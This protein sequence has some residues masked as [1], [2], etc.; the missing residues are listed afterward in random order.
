MTVHRRSWIAGTIV[1]ILVG[2][3]TATMAQNRPAPAAPDALLA[4]APRLVWERIV[5]LPATRTPADDEHR[6]W[7]LRAL[8]ARGDGGALIVAGGTSGEAARLIGVRGDGADAF[9][10]PLPAPA[11]VGKKPVLRSAALNGEGRDRI[12]VFL[13]WRPAGEP[14]VGPVA[15]Q[16]IGIDG[17]AYR[18]VVRQ[19]P[20]FVHRGLDPRGPL[21]VDEREATVLRR[22]PDGSLLAGGTAY[23][24]PPAWWFARFTVDGTLFHER[25]TRL[26]PTSVEDARGN[27]DG[28]YSLLL[29]EAPP[30]LLR[31]GADGKSKTRRSFEGFR[32]DGDCAVLTGANTHLRYDPEYERKQPDHGDTLARG[33]LVLVDADGGVARRI[34]MGANECAALRRTGDGIVLVATPAGA[35]DTPPMIVAGFTPTGEQ[36]W[37]L[38]LPAGVARVE[39]LAD[40]GVLVARP[41]VV[42]GK[43]VVKLARYRAP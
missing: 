2:V 14:D 13:T 29:V 17:P 9:S 8:A 1:S 40:G 10:M 36:R 26:Y 33:R 3:T 37:R 35:G 39:P 43:P 41:G 18:T 19:L 32:S 7:N 5:D 34:G 15:T 23:F 20:R 16:L 25:T 6:P 42:D 12:W 38:D 22:L 30:T 21:E 27:E 4:P 31:Y 24:G 11:G 28:G